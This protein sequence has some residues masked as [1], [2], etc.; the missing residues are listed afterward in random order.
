MS[1]GVTYSALFTED[2]TCTI[3][4]VRENENKFAFKN[5]IKLI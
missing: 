3:L 4:P 2:L 5:A 1:G